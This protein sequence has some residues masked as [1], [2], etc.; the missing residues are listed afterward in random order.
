MPNPFRQDLRDRGR[1]AERPRRGEIRR[2]MAGQRQS[3]ESEAVRVVA[4][5]LTA[6]RQP[7]K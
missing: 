5:L 3:P 6:V 2:Y 4:G 7:E 1:K